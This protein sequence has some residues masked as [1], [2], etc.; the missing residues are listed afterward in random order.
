[1]IRAK[2]E[3]IPKLVALLAE[4]FKDN[5]SANFAVKNKKSLPGL[6]K[7]SVAKGFLFGDVWMNED[8]TACAILLDPKKKKSGLQSVLLD[9]QLI[10]KVV[11]LSK[12]KK[13]LKK[14]NITEQTLPQ[15]VDYIH[16]WFLGVVP[17]LQGNGIGTSFLQELIEYYKSSKEAMCLETSTLV[18]IPF[19]EKQG[20]SRYATKYFGFEFFFYIKQF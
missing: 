1:M 19:Y 12:I 13:V 4:S 3:D 18:N 10:V 15:N 20:F 8:K 17:K 14:E 7:Y 11:G 2:K 9:L 16:L 6:F 5:Q